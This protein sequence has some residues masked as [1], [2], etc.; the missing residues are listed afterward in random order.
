MSLRLAAAFCL[1]SL[2][3]C[4]TTPREAAAPR[5][6]AIKPELPATVQPDVVAERAV[7]A[8]WPFPVRAS[9]DGFDKPPDF[10]ASLRNR[11]LRPLAE[12]R[13]AAR[14]ARVEIRCEDAEYEQWSCVVALRDGTAPV[15]LTRNSAFY[16]GRKAD[17]YQ[18][19]RQSVLAALA[20]E[21]DM[22]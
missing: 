5:P 17:P 16:D 10:V 8:D 7:E 6:I 21:R 13:F 11:F 2:T 9:I 4:V 18:A 1:F 20:A 14:I 12:S 15:H 3:S 19:A 22:R